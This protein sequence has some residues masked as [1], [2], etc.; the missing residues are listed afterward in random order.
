MEQ[1]LVLPICSKDIHKGENVPRA[2]ALRNVLP[3][4]LFYLR[5]DVKAGKTR[6]I[7]RSCRAL[8]DRKGQGAGSADGVRL[9]NHAERC[10][11]K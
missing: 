11:A 3:V 8:K 5:L 7:T 4:S 1:S 9:S 10:A 6:K 2:S